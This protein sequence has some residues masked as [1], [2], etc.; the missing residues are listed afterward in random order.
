MKI[1]QLAGSLFPVV[2]RLCP[3]REKVVVFALQG[4]GVVRLPTFS[5]V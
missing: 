1:K 2:M 4:A 3:Q 5:Q